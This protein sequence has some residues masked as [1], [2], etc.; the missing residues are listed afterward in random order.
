VE[1]SDEEKEDP[2]TAVICPSTTDTVFVVNK[3]KFQS[4]FCG[5]LLCLPFTTALHTKINPTQN[6][7]ETK[8]K[9]VIFQQHKV[10]IFDK[11]RLILEFFGEKIL[12]SKK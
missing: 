3:C 1:V 6:C 5:I 11:T 2:Y 9:C 7:G 10:Q 12:N 4:S 8:Q